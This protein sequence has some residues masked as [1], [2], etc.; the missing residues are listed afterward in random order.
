M[1]KIPI[2]DVRYPQHLRVSGGLETTV[3][4]LNADGN[5]MQTTF[6]TR[7]EV[8]T[9]WVIALF[10]VGGSTTHDE[11]ITFLPIDDQPNSI[12]A[13]E[14]GSLL[15]HTVTASPATIQPVEDEANIFGVDVAKN[16]R[17]EPQTFLGIGGTK[18]CLVLHLDLVGLNITFTR[19]TYQVTVLTKAEP[20]PEVISNL[21]PS[22]TPA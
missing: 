22:K 3:P 21:A 17:L 8:Y 4:V 7:M 14:R 6:R 13:Y 11:A 16:V 18:F 15:D 2:G 9:G 1:A 19:F 20:A 12:L 10:A 5:E